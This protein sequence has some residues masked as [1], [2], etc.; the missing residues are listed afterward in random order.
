M[1]LDDGRTIIRKVDDVYRKAPDEMGIRRI[2]KDQPE[3]DSMIAF[4]KSVRDWE[5]P[6]EE[7]MSMYRKSREDPGDYR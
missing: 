1:E 4:I 6:E 5:V 2:A 3:D 7:R